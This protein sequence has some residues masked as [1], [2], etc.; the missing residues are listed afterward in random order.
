MTELMTD[1]VGAFIMYDLAIC[2][3]AFGIDLLLKARG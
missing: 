2:S 1:I 3:L